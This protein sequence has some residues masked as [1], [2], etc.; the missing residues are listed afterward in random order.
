M[1]T[2]LFRLYEPAAAAQE[3]VLRK[4]MRGGADSFVGRRYGLTPKTDACGF[5]RKMPLH[6][7]DALEPYILRQMGGEDRVLWNSRCLYY[8]RS[9]GTS[10]SKSKYIPVTQENLRGCH[11]RGFMMMLASYVSSNPH[12]K[13]YA[14][15]SLTIAGSIEKDAERGIWAGDLS[16]ILMANS[17]RLAE[18]LR[19]PRR[20]IA[21]IRDFNEKLRAVFDEYARRRVVSFAGVPSWNLMMLERMVEWA[22]TDNVCG[23]WPDMELF[24]HGGT[25]FGPY[26]RLFEELIPSPKMH[27][28]E[29]YNASEGYFAFQDD[30]SQPGMLL[31]V[32]NGVYYE[33]IPMDRLDEALRDAEAMRADGISDGR[34]VEFDT[35]ETVRKGVD[36]AMVISTTAGLWRYLIGDCVRFVS[37]DPC[38]IVITGRT[39]L[40]INAFGEELMIGN[41]E[42]ALT[43]ACGKFGVGVRDYMVAPVFMAE[44]SDSEGRRLARGRHQWLVEFSGKVPDTAAFASC[45]DGCLQEVNSDYE[46]KRTHTHTMDPLELIAVPEGTFAGWMASRGKY[47][48]QNKVPRLDGGRQLMD[49]V[50][51]YIASGTDFERQGASD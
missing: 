19:A 42:A 8:A 13:L 29:N 32:N 14:G 9:S 11:Y 26:R 21:L 41:A 34:Y 45:L 39:K 3:D 35:L 37:L 51:S 46:A 4:L 23:F 50:L 7:Y 16:G 47:G 25:A 15:K 40:F 20:E 31:T 48:G 5:R 30:L 12:T 44:Q 36:Y 38:R 33:F 10:S 49:S 1:L 24:M 2:R 43:A 28:L 18:L 17:P 6:D 27:Y 22:G